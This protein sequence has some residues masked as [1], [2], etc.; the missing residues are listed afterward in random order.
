[1]HFNLFENSAF[2][3]KN[4]GGANESTWKK[5][6]TYNIFLTILFSNFSLTTGEKFFDKKFPSF[7]V[8]INMYKRFTMKTYIKRYVS[9]CLGIP[10]NKVLHYKNKCNIYSLLHVKYAQIS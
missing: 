8:L 7:L 9:C 6:F 5:T 10:S 2:L 4:D 1:M 3:Q